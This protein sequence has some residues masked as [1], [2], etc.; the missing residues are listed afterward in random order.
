MMY[1]WVVLVLFQSVI[2]YYVVCCVEKMLLYD[3]VDDEV[4]RSFH[5]MSLANLIF[6]SMKEGACSEQ[7]SR[8]TAMDAASKNAGQFS[9]VFSCGDL[10]PLA[11]CVCVCVCLRSGEMIDKLTLTY[12]RTRQAVITRELIEII[13]GAAAV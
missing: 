2:L 12:N 3:D 6:Y 4:L 9:G 7:S 13:S 11:V 8:M 1:I 5:E 10:Y